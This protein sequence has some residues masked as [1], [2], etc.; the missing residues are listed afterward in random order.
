MPYDKIEKI[1]YMV[2]LNVV[3]IA[4]KYKVLISIRDIISNID[5]SW[6]KAKDVNLLQSNGS[7]SLK[8]ILT[9]NTIAKT[10]KKIY[11]DP[12]STLRCA[13]KKGGPPNHRGPS[14]ILTE[15]EENQLV[16]YCMNMQQLEFGLTKSGFVLIPKLEKVIAKKGSHQVH[17]VVHSNSHEHISVIPTISAVGSYISPLV[18]YKDVH[19]IPGLLQDAPPGAV[20]SFTDTEY[21]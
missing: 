16:G 15:H 21:M 3:D 5:I 7:L 1:T 13:I 10:F 12:T 17:K 9:S 19:A 4:S 8:N 11:N 14:T 2:S 18:I 6:L 20:M